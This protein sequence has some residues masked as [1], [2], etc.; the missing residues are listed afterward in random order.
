GRYNGERFTVVSAFEAVGQFCG[1]KIDRE[2]LLEIERHACP[3]AGSCGG[4]YT[5]NTM[6]AAIEAM[7]MSLP[8]SS[9]M[10]AEDSD[11]AL[12]ATRS[13]RALASA[14]GKQILPRQILTRKA[15]E[16]AISVVM[17]IGGSTNAVL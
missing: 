6:S 7:G 16:N 5:A 15:F 17:A 13:A 9:T 2:K 4:M 11:K 14:V 10:A 1:G 8:Y 12:D 3:G